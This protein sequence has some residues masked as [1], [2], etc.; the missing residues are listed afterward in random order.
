MPTS[1]ARRW[2]RTMLGTLV[3]AMSAC[4]RTGAPDAIPAPKPE[5]SPM[6]SRDAA[7]ARLT[8]TDDPALP[9]VQQ[10]VADAKNDV[11]TLPTTRAEGER[12]ILCVGV[13]ARSPLGAVALHTGGL[14][15]DHGWLRILGAGKHGLCAWNGT[16]E[17][18]VIDPPDGTLIVGHDVIGGFFALDGGGLGEGRG[19]VFYF[20]P[21]TLQW[22]PLDVGYSEWLAWALDGDLE[23]FYEGTRWTG[24]QED[25]RALG[26]HRAMLVQPPLWTNEADVGN[27]QRG[28][29]PTAELWTLQRDMARQL[30]R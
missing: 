5:V 12:A 21:D 2:T 3:L 13:S 28:E 8:T 26:M 25:A 11:E 23:G 16:G 7:L 6:D 14:R 18:R 20:A 30:G 24:W 15:V 22:E 29:V 19:K 10:W 27:G 1:S 9:L 4:P 17:D